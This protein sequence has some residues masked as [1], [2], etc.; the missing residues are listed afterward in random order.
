MV[1]LIIFDWD[2][3]LCLGARESYYRLYA[4]SLLA[5]GVTQP[6]SYIADTVQGFW[7]RPHR[8][9]LRELLPKDSP[10]LD[11]AD[12]AYQ[13]LLFSDV[14]FVGLHLPLGLGEMLEQLSFYYKLA[15]ATS[16]D[17][18]LV[19]QHLLARLGLPD[20]FRQMVTYQDLANPSRGKPYP[21]LVNLVLEREQV[22]YDEAIVVGDSA[23]DVA[24]AVTAGC[25]PV[26]VLTGNLSRL[27]AERMGVH[28]ILEQVTDLPSMLQ[29]RDE[30][31]AGT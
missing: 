30:T 11:A 6:A 8:E 22:Q 27:E 23:V 25:I 4:Q 24:M 26:V 31:I 3:V 19:K 1:K 9:V 16:A 21:D 20:V 2:N 15:I 28:F 7:G 5:A 14:F 13:R 17:G 12:A 18:V 10:A 29:G